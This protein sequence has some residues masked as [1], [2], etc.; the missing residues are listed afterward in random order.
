MKWFIDKKGINS[1][2]LKELKSHFK[3]DTFSNKLINILTNQISCNPDI[4]L[5]TD[6]FKFLDTMAKQILVI[7]H[8]QNIN[9]DTIEDNYEQIY[10]SKRILNKEIKKK[11]TVYSKINTISSREDNTLSYHF[12]FTKNKNDSHLLI[13]YDADLM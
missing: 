5:K 6:N 4:T 2:N 1:E 13:I 9:I 10:I 8:K 3:E 12:H 11:N 7:F